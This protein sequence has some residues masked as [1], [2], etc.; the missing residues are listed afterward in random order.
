MIEVYDSGLVNFWTCRGVNRWI[1]VESGFH[2]YLFN[3]SGICVCGFV[4][5]NAFIESAGLLEKGS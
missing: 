4:F 1:K 3:V 2:G 5:G